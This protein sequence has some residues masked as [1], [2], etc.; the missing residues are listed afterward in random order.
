MIHTK[1][2]RSKTLNVIILL[3]AALMAVPS[4]GA[5]SF[6]VLHAFSSNSSP[7]A[8]VVQG[9]DGAFYGTTLY[10]GVPG[11]G[12]VFRVTDNG[13]FTNLVVF[14]FS[15]G[16]HPFAGLTLGPD[17]ALYGTTATGGPLGAGTVFRLTTDGEFT[18]IGAFA[19]QNGQGPRGLTLGSNGFLYGTTVAGGVY[20]NQ[21]GFG[22]GTVFRI[23][24]NGFLSSLASFAGT[25]GWS[26][27]G[28]LVEGDDGAFHG[29]TRFGG[30]Y[31]NNSPNG[32]GTVFKVTTNGVLTSLV[33]FAGTNGSRPFSGLAKARDGAFY[34][35]AAGGTAG[36]GTVYRVTSSGQLTVLVNFDRDFTGVYPGAGLVEG[37]DGALYGTT[38][39]G[40]FSPDTFGGTIFRV[41]T[42]GELSAVYSFAEAD[43]RWPAASLIQASNG[44]FYGTCEYGG[45]LANGGTVFRL[46][47]AVRLA[48]PKTVAQGLELT[49]KGL[50]RTSYT[51]LRT[52]N[53]SG[54]WSEISNVIPDTNGTATC[55][56]IS[57]PMGRAF[58]RTFIPV[59]NW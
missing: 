13:L 21:N 51:L 17:G 46:D 11:Y 55:L 16:A 25:N 22:Y 42:N 44:A 52:T 29:T 48:P 8:P 33:S 5:A 19:I 9:N 58:Y 35:T 53:V 45:S 43:G 24:T 47:L 56:D 7:T 15:N 38:T 12:T 57:P 20:T 26:P 6:Q 14:N 4:A 41:T 1:L 59:L 39:Q 32:S 37:D 18:T 36:W 23:A 50:P 31:T 10:G 2:T 34:G 28:N 49:F 30:S 3:A 27:A 40:T 54:D